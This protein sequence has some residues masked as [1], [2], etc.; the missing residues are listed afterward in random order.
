MKLQS[1]LG[2]FLWTKTKVFKRLHAV[3]AVNGAT[4]SQMDRVEGNISGSSAEMLTKRPVLLL[5]GHKLAPRPGVFAVLDFHEMDVPLIGY[6]L[7]G[8]GPWTKAGRLLLLLRA[9][10]PL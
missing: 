3:R 4:H 10:H 7:Q 5:G 2:S 8:Y 9:P 6:E 1:K